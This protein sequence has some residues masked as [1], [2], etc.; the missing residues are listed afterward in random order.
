MVQELL[1]HRAPLEAQ[2]NEYKATPLGWALHGSEHG[3][4]R[5]KGEYGQVVEALLAAGAKAPTLAGLEAS[6][7]VLAV[8]RRHS[9]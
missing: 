9:G 7:E 3:W 8:L 5:D 4:H 6:E 1:R 2:E